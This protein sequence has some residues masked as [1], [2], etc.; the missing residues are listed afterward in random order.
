MSAPVRIYHF[1]LSGHAHRV[2]LFAGLAGIDHKLVEV[3]LAQGEHK[4]APYLAIN[5]LGQVPA[6]QDGETIIT[7]SNAILVYLARKFA[8][9][10][11]PDDPLHQA[12][13]Q[14]FLSL[15]AG[16]LRTGPANARLANVFGADIDRPR[17]EAA[18]A[19]LFTHLDQHLEN[20]D[21]L[22]ADRATIAD[23]ALYS[24][25]A[26]APEGGLSLEPYPFIREWL[27]RVESLPGFVPMPRT[28][29]GLAA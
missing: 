21:W 11:L 13:V 24:Y 2:A 23:I 5:P 9:D 27:K 8:P 10:W 12:R 1:P 17:A 4:Q 14:Q 29:A 19:W 28:R 15:A 26:H 22:A 3:N 20:S 25:T 7:D 16:E 18:A 6:L